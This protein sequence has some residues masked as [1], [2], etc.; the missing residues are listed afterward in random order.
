[1]SLKIK[2]FKHMKNLRYLSILVLL[3]IISG[4]TIG[5]GA[6]YGKTKV[7]FPG[8]GNEGD[9]RILNAGEGYEYSSVSDA[10]A[11]AADGDTINIYPGIYREFGLIVEHSVVIIGHE[12]PVIDVDYQGE[13]IRVKADN[14]HIEGLEIRNVPTSHSRDHAAIRFERV[15]GGRIINNRFDD[16]F[17]GIYLARSHDVEIRDNFLRSY[18]T[19]ESVSANGIHLWNSNR[20]IIANNIIIGHRDGI[21]LEYVQESTIQ[22]NQAEKNIRYGLHF[23]FSDDCIYHHNRFENNGAGVAVMYSKR[24]KMKQNSFIHNWGSSSYGLL[25]KELT[26]SEIVQN[27][28]IRNTIGIRAEG[29]DRV[30][31]YH[32][33]FLHNGWAIR[34]MANS[35]DNII[36]G[37][38]FIDNAFDVSTNSR[39]NNSKFEAN[40]WDKYSGYDLKG[41]G[42]GDV[43]YRPVR[44]FSLIVE[45]NP[46]ALMLLRSLF[47]EILDLT[48][49]IMPTI[50]PETLVD[51][52]PLMQEVS[53]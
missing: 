32:N 7:S 8:Y 15:K 44:L 37:N 22:D 29:T 4:F 50:T 19:R 45:R 39:Q 28:F 2:I 30:K 35:M 47:V 49:R 5:N 14:V 23:M 46:M 21:Y 13:G 43:P 53:L 16:T 9:S 36:T 34:I 12:R 1:M 42:F 48:E 27:S 18:H 17:F 40:Y 26:D 41:D 20:A 31:I 33:E 24:V 51:E 52:K 11:M 25:L 3:N 10:L 38:N 6:S